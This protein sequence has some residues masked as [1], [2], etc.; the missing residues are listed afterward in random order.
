MPRRLLVITAT[1]ALASCLLIAAASGKSHREGGIFRIAGLPSSID[2][3]IS[4]EASTELNA[5]CA[6]LMNYPDKPSPAGTRL[7]PEVAAGYPAV[8]R[9]GTTFTFAIKSSFRFNTGEQVT[10]QSFAHEIDRILSPAM[11][12]PWVQYVQDI[13]G[14]K[15]VTDGKASTPS[16]MKIRGNKL[17][18]RLTHAARDFP[19]RV[20]A[21]P[22]CAVPADLPITPEGVTT[23]PSAGPYYVDEFVGGQKLILKKNPLYRGTRPHHVDE[24]DVS[25]S[26]DPVRAVER[27]EADFADADPSQS[28]PKYRSQLHAVPGQLVRFIVFNSSQ[29]LFK[30][31]VALRRAIN[32]AIDR[33]ALIRER[34]T[35]TGRPTDQ[36]LTAS[37]PGFVDAHIYPLG[38]PRTAKAKALARGHTGNGKAVLYIQDK[39]ESIAQAQIIQ[40]DLRPIGL[41]VSVKKF[42]G[43]ALFQRL[44]T[45]GTPYDMTLLGFGPDWFDPYAMLNVLFDGRLIGTPYNFNLAYYNSPKYNARLAAASKLTGSPRYR[46][47]GKLDVDLARREAPVAAYEAENAL[48]FV[49]KRVGCLVLHPFFDLAAACLK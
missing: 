35:I 23:L 19:A 30:D 38:R 25:A 14:A 17:I 34:G 18:I 49:S 22:F 6:L 31:N 3:A 4:I 37:M 36:Y 7:I 10:A 33:P 16:G 43:P 39:P 8:S 48:T 47:Y 29:P 13:V 45:P 11:K 24:V 1:L 12:S 15:A 42:P 44:F 27:G 9:A 5:T 28:A 32:F 26:T 20:T 46:A 21:P 2:P 41:T 40:R